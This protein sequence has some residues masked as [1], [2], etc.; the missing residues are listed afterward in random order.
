MTY[1]ATHHAWPAVIAGAQMFSAL[2]WIATA[3]HFWPSV[4][5]IVR[6][7]STSLW[8]VPGCWAWG[9]GMME[10]A[11]VVWWMTFGRGTLDNM[12]TIAMVTRTMLWFL[13]A[14]LA[15]GILHSWRNPDCAG[16]IARARRGLIMWLGVGAACIGV[17]LWF[18]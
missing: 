8:D 18:V 4:V 3:H 16:G 10:T 12:P 11:I 1:S 6:R 13:S 9:M 15:I 7:T 14:G 17:S 5:R 2:A